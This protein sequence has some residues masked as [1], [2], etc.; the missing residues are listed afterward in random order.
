MFL[1][2]VLIFIKGCQV[3]IYTAENNGYIG[4]VLVNDKDQEYTSSSFKKEPSE[5][6][7]TKG[8][9]RA[10]FYVLANKPLNARVAPKLFIHTST[11]EKHDG[12]TKEHLNEF[13]QGVNAS[14]HVKKFIKDT[15]MFYEIPML[16]E[17]TERDKYF[18]M[19]ADIKA[20]QQNQTDIIHSVTK[21]KNRI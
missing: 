1:L 12:T 20:K 6:G 17:Y 21:T 10:L 13:K 7:H 16:E 5:E 8:V 3:K 19:V 9:E 2:W 4:Y 15:G 14:L 11:K 18:L